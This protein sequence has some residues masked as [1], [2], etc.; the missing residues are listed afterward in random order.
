MRRVRYHVA[1]SLDGYIAEADG[2]Y[3]WIPH[4]PDIDFAALFNQFDTFLIGR[5]TYEVMVRAGQGTMPGKRLFIFSRTL[6]QRDYPDVTIVA[7]DQEKLVNSL[8][9]EAGKDI[10]LFGGGELFASLLKA[11][12]VDTVEIAV[13]PVLLGG[14]IPMLLPP[15]VQT[16]LKLTGHTIY[17]KSGIVWLAYDIVNGGRRERREE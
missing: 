10:W 14:G 15:S 17:E 4:D 12:L 13:L 5:R 7:A 2:G 11:G 3:D 1:M 16:K 8:R 9:A 6:Q